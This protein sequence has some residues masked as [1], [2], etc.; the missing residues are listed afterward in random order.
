MTLR[1]MQP[2]QSVTEGILMQL[3]EG[4]VIELNGKI[5]TKWAGLIVAPD[6]DAY[7]WIETN[8]RIEFFD[9]YVIRIAYASPYRFQQ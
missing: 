8:V 4:N 2:T 3:K 9:K 6:R 5:F 7:E 1:M